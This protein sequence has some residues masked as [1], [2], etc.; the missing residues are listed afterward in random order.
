MSLAERL[1]RLGFEVDRIIPT[2]GQEATGE[3]FWQSVR[4][5][6]EGG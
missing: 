3:V 5:G 4:L 2:H 6:R 1:E